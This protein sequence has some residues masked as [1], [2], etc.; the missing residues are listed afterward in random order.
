MKRPEEARVGRASRQKRR[1]TSRMK[2]PRTSALTLWFGR[3]ATGMSLSSRSLHGLRLHG[4]ARDEIERDPHHGER[5]VFGV[6]RLAGARPRNERKASADAPARGDG[7]RAG[8]VERAADLDASTAR[9]ARARGEGDE[10]VKRH[11]I[12]G[13]GGRSRA[14]GEG[15][16]AGAVKGEG[17]RDA[18]CEGYA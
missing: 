18:F 12:D 5:D 1:P 15:L 9:R 16:E 7:V 4:E 3:V 11:P 6:G 13:D 2:T 14:S 10:G 17:R 8:R